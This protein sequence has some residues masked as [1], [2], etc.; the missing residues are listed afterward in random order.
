MISVFLLYLY[1]LFLTILITISIFIFIINVLV[2]NLI[3]IASNFFIN[4]LN[5]LYRVL[6]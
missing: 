1:I 5:L 4:I 2:I 3:N 6:N